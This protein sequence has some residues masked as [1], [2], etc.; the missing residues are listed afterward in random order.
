MRE[1][2][3]APEYSNTND[4]GLNMQVRLVK[5]ALQ[6]GIYSIEGKWLT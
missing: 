6:C 2:E 1:L 5:K 3:K 4:R